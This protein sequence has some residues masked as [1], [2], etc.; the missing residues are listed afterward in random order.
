MAD[1][2]VAA[3]AKTRRLASLVWWRQKAI[4]V[5]FVCIFAVF[6]FSLRDQGFLEPTTL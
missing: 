5:G 1:A 4:Y 6:S 2:V 3:P